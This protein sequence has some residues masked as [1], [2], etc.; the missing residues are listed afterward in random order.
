MEKQT[1]KIVTPSISYGSQVLA[2][3]ESILTVTATEPYKCKHCDEDITIEQIKEVVGSID[4]VV[5]T[6]VLE[7]LNKYRKES[8]YKLDTCLRKAH[9]IT[10][11]AS[12]TQFKNMKE[13][14]NYYY[15]KLSLG[16][17][18]SKKR[19]IDNTIL[20]SLESHLT[21]IFE[22]R[23]KDDEKIEKTNAEVK[24]IVKNASIDSDIRQL[25]AKRIKKVGKVKTTLSEEVLKEVLETVK[26]KNG[27]D[28]E[29]VKYKII[30][31]KRTKGYTMQIFSRG[32]AKNRY[33]KNGNEL[34]R[35]GY[36]F[37]GKGIK[38][39]TGR[40]NYN[41]FSN[42]RLGLQ[43]PDDDS[44]FID[45]TKTTDTA[46][47]KGNYDKLADKENVMYGVQGAIWYWLEG[48]G[49]VYKGSDSDDVFMVSYRINGGFNGFDDG[50]YPRKK[51]IIKARKAFKV[52]DHY[53]L[54][55]EH[56]SN[57]NKE[58]VLNNNLRRIGK[59]HVRTKKN[60]TKTIEADPKGKE[61]WDKFKPKPIKLK[62][63]GI[64]LK[65]E[66]KPELI[67]TP[68]NISK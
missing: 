30:L 46:N 32:Y 47:V 65:I 26:D 1:R 10:Q 41:Q 66:L 29:Q 38:Q 31:K 3:K 57:A 52:Y 36:K 11:V 61:L 20:T 51:G 64:D 35:D 39:L 28:V 56:G 60:H 25:Y 62:P 67:L 48:N 8:E 44:G 40:Y 19:K 45:F 21:E 53:K 63:K 55:M 22:I 50:G 7:Y 13:G 5:A 68:I 27:N 34:S 12:E 59:T 49:K 54:T 24:E 17:F 37:S 9:F 23:N 15:N 58:E 33:L 43:F 16:S 2:Y 4:T 42:K 6:K 18:S 14:G